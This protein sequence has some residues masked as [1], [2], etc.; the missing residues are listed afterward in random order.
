MARA[1]IPIPSEEVAVGV[2][3]W[4]CLKGN[5]TARVKC[6]DRPCSIQELQFDP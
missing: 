2:K 1:P 5:V 6:I 3:R 4:F